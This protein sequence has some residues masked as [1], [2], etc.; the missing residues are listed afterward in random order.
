MF[1]HH[2]TSPCSGR[3]SL[4]LDVLRCLPLPLAHL[5]GAIFNKSSSFRRLNRKPDPF[6]GFVLPKLN[7]SC[8]PSKFRPV[9]TQPQT[10]LSLRII[11]NS[12]L[13]HCLRQPR[14][15]PRYRLLRPLQRRCGFQRSPLPLPQQCALSPLQIRLCLSSNTIF[16]FASSINPALKYATLPPVFEESSATC[17]AK[18]CTPAVGDI[19]QLNVTDLGSSARMKK[20]RPGVPK[21]Q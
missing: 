14:R 3:L 21:K 11:C 6:I 19:H 1:I 7:H 8:S 16:M 15:P 12:I 13:Q 2:S 9:A 5:V 20:A 4:S 17:P 18:F 10:G